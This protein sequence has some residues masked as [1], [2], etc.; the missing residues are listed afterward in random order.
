MLGIIGTMPIVLYFS[1]KQA[2]DFNL[3]IDILSLELV[4]L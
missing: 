1:R 2:K 3:D 4:S